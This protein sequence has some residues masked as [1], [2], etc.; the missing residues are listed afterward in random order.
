KI[1]NALVAISPDDLEHAMYDRVDRYHSRKH[2]VQ[3]ILPISSRATAAVHVASRMSCR[4]VA[5]SITVLSLFRGK[6]P[7]HKDIVSILMSA[8]YSAN[9]TW[10][11]DG[12]C[13]FGKNWIF[14]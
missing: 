9:T 3:S 1:N 11:C 6:V 12:G 8:R 14:I 2:F 10:K 4:G 13:S 7:F 5:H